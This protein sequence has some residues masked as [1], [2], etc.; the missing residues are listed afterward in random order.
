MPLK[1]G[2]KRY[3]QILLDNARYELLENKACKNGMRVTGLARQAIYEWIERNHSEEE[4]TAALKIDTEQWAE[5]MRN[6]IDGRKKQK[7]VD[8]DS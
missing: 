5:S 2:N 6:R 8:T 3:M 1:H 4:Y 7:P